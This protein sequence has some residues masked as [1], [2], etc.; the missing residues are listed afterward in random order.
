VFVFAVCLAPTSG[1]AAPAEAL[2]QCFAN[3]TTGKDRIALAQWIFSGMALHPETAKLAVI[4]PE[5]RQEI[6]MAM[7]TL[8]TRLLTDACV[9]EF[10]EAT[11][12]EGPTAVNAAFGVLGG[13]AMR[14]LT[15]DPTVAAGAVAFQKY[16]DTKKLRDCLQ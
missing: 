1:A 15:S 9:N 14:E 7:G 6:N 12:A 2:S 11:R 16:I 5:Q 10:R 13:L 4:T 8:V 3:S